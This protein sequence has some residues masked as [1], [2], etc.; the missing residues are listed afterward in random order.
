MCLTRAHAVAI[1]ALPRRLEVD[2]VSLL[3]RTKAGD[4]LYFPTLLSILGVI[5][6][7]EAPLDLGKV[8][9]GPYYAGTSSAE[10]EAANSATTTAAHAALP[11]S[12]ASSSSSE[13]S[14]PSSSSSSSFSLS[15]PSL[16]S[17]LLA[18][19]SSSSPWR[20]LLLYSFL[21]ACICIHGCW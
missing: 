18:S 13:S 12:N 2:V 19:L 9:L 11:S 3:R 8:S 10:N 1:C 15:L 21:I 17:S 16:S 7:V 6:Q 20:R 14:S 4:E 5:P